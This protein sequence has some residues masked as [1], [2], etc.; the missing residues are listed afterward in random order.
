[1]QQLAEEERTEEL[2]RQH[3]IKLET[4]FRKRIEAQQAHREQMASRMKKL[5]HEAQEE[6][7]Y[8]QQ[9]SIYEN[10]ANSYPVRDQ[11]F[12]LDLLNC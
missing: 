2:E 4:E 11:D 6:A 8:R 9:V 5:Q 12:V 1:M 7:A 10:T 3:Q